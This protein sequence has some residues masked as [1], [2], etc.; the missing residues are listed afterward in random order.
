M[1]YVTRGENKKIVAVY[2]NLQEGYAE[3]ELLDDD[4]EVIAFLTPKPQPR[5][6]PKRVIIDRLYAAGKLE[7]AKAALDAQSLYTQERWNS[8]E[9]I[10]ATDPDTIALLTAI[11]ADPEKILA[12]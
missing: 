12:E 9:S 3:E 11:G 1:V 8:R 10:Y 6:V 5:L 2:A 7:V 4:A